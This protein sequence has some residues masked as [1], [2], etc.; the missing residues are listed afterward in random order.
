M[1][2]QTPR[3]WWITAGYTVFAQEGPEA[4]KVEPLAKLVGVSKTSFYHFFSDMG[5]FRSALLAQHVAQSAV[6][7]AKEKN[8]RNI[9]PELIGIL[10]EHK[11]D[12]LFNRQLRIHQDVPEY[13][14]ALAESDKLVNDFFMLLWMRELN[15][16]MN[17]QQLE[18]MFQLAIQHFYLQLTPE[19]LNESW[20]REYFIQL[21]KIAL[22]FTP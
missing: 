22:Q 16:Q 18:G 6:V 20:L 5:A 19:N 12:L 21:R 3:Q 4:L 17:V 13:A 15:M 14:A 8:C 1:D 10:L 7:G 9:D 2:Q 11:M